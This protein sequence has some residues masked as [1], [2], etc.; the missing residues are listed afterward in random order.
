[1]L[2]QV[3]NFCQFCQKSQK[4]YK[5]RSH[6]SFLKKVKKKRKSPKC[7]KR[8]RN[9]NNQNSRKNAEKARKSKKTEKTKKL[10][11]PKVPKLPG[12]PKTPKMP[13]MFITPRLPNLPRLP[14]FLRLQRLSILPR[15]KNYFLK[16]FN[17][18]VFLEKTNRSFEIILNLIQ[19]RERRQLCYKLRI[20]WFY[21]L[22][23]SSFLIMRF[24][25]KNSKNFNVGKL[26]KY[27][28]ERVF[29][30]KKSFHHFESHVRKNGE[31]QNMSG[32]AGR[33]VCLFFQLSSS[34]DTL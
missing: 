18:W 8:H 21:F 7:Q 24:F 29:F 26:R 19:R 13:I 9:Q 14:T 1:M 25:C 31:A 32:V 17:S 27:D 20:K 34:A 15:L 3:I 16:T 30:G 2:A 10:S 28:E 22:K 23:M 12:M 5:S 11:N 33:L 4:N 6:Q